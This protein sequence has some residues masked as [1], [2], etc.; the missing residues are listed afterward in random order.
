MK[1]VLRFTFGLVMVV[2]IGGLL[3]LLTRYLHPEWW[4]RRLV[5]RVVYG[6]PA[7]T[8]VVSSLWLVGFGLRAQWLFR[9]AAFGTAVGLVFMLGLILALPLS[10]I[11]LRA[12]ALWLRW[13]RERADEALALL[14]SHLQFLRFASR[15]DDG[16]DDLVSGH[17]GIGRVLRYVN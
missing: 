5:R 17:F 16:T 11:V 7:V 14:A 2:G 13:R 15:F 8:L 10:G 1:W 3:V 9:P 12:R 6:L 4:R